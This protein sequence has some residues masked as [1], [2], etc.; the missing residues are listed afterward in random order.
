MP[1]VNGSW[2]WIRLLQFRRRVEYQPRSGC[3]TEPN[4]AAQRLRVA[5]RR[6]NPGLWVL[7][8]FAVPLFSLNSKP[9]SRARRPCHSNYSCF[10][11]SSAA[12][13]MQ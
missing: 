6:G 2:C 10:S 4:V 1:E 13:F 8:R 7:N 11:N 12:E 5:A 9:Q 3:G